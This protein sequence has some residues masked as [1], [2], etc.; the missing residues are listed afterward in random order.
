VRYV[1]HQFAH[2]ETLERARRWLVQVGIDPI[3]I[4]A[5]TRGILNLAVAAEG[6]ESAEVQRIFDVAE[7]AD[8]DGNPGIWHRA[9]RRPAYP[10]AETAA[11]TDGIA[12]RPH[13]FDF[14]W[15]PPDADRD[16][17]Q[18]D[19]GVELQKRHHEERD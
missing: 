14:S 9:A 11:R 10:G 13:S 1:T 17:T 12:T 2:V 5:R 15:H 19:A 18:T 3:R 16:A 7:F 4:E 6:G 8:P